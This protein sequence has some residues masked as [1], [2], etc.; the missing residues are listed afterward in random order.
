MK[1]KSKPFLCRYGWHRWAKGKRVKGF[2]V[3]KCDRCGERQEQHFPGGAWKTVALLKRRKL[4]LQSPADE[5]RAD[6]ERG[7]GA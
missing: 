7:I 5:V 2:L 4:R 6:R 1:P 3:R